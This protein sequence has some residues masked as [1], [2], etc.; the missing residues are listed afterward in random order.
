MLQRVA[1]LSP[2][3]RQV[4]DFVAKGLRN[5][6]IAEALELSVR[7]VEMHRTRLMRRLGARSPGEIASIIAAGAGES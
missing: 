6:Q 5:L 3:E 1:S 4:A 7:T 2:R